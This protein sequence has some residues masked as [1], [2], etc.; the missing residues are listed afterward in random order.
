MKFPLKH[1]PLC[2]VSKDSV[3]VED[4]V[5]HEIHGF[6]TTGKPGPNLTLRQKDYHK[7]FYYPDM[8]SDEVLLF[9]QF[10]QMKGVDN[11]TAD[12]K[13]LGNFHTAFK[14]PN[15]GEAKEDRM[16]CEHRVELYFKKKEGTTTTV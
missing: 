11:T 7:Y 10:E 12:A 6:T 14:D 4:C 9:T 3:T 1:M 2:V 15:A 5:W 16:S 8:T 13:V